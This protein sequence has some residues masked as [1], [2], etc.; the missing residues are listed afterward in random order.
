MSYPR[1]LWEV[2]TDFGSTRAYDPS[3]HTY[4]YTTLLRHLT[5]QSLSSVYLRR[6]LDFCEAVA[7][8]SDLHRRT[9]G[10]SVLPGIQIDESESYRLVG[11]LQ[12]T[13]KEKGRPTYFVTLTC[14][15]R[16]FPG[17]REV[18]SHIESRGSSH[19]LATAHT[20]RVWNRSLELFFSWLQQDPGQP[21]GSIKHYW[22][23]TEFS[24]AASN[25][26]HV[27][28]LIWNEDFNHVGR[29]RD[30]EGF[31]TGERAALSRV[32]GST[33][34]H[35][36]H[37]VACERERERLSALAKRLLT[38]NCTQTCRSKGCP[39]HFPARAT[40]K[41][42]LQ[43]VNDEVPS[44]IAEVLKELG[45]AAPG[46]KGDRLGYDYR[47]V[48][49]HPRRFRG[50]EYV[51][52][53]VPELFIAAESHLNVQVVSSDMQAAYLCS[54]T[55]KLQ[56][57]TLGHLRKTGPATEFVGSSF[58]VCEHPLTA[59]LISHTEVVNAIL[60]NPLVSSDLSYRHLSAGPREERFVQLLGGKR[61]KPTSFTLTPR[62][63][64]G[65]LA[66]RPAS[67]ALRALN[68]IYQS[69]YTCDSIQ[70]YEVRPP[71]LGFMGLKEYYQYTIQAPTITSG[72][73]NQ[74]ITNHLVCGLFD[75]R[76][77][78]VRVAEAMFTDHT[79]RSEMLV[80][81]M[82]QNLDIPQDTAWVRALTCRSPHR[83]EDVPRWVDNPA[84]K[85]VVVLRQYIPFLDY[86]WSYQQKLL[87]RPF[88]DEQV[89]QREPDPI[90]SQLDK[91]RIFLAQMRF[92]PKPQ[93][94]TWDKLH[95]M[96]QKGYAVLSG[97]LLSDVQLRERNRQRYEE[98]VKRLKTRQA[99]HLLSIQLPG[100][101]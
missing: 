1:Y 62:T 16:N 51:S 47:A 36:F 56:H 26:G 23:R 8:D 18:T 14:N 44:S 4:A 81:L 68:R 24:D 66:R 78:E 33:H 7:T 57:R 41:M 70:I 83:S 34:S 76:G 48:R 20:T 64:D 90:L 86:R 88:T 29:T 72:L 96:L 2:L 13:L 95:Q 12:A 39:Q 82:L 15:P 25:L 54:Y 55:A 89:V 50:D 91:A 79:A 85:V 11:E 61:V 99:S 42:W 22:R 94:Y 40:G 69:K 58:E 74:Q 84:P 37:V 71:E 45:Y 87:R 63:E 60:Q 77:H 21:L 100:L 67:G 31:T 3:W 30:R 80:L 6:G 9:F 46:I 53:Y 49:Y 43:V 97:Q 75:L 73:T 17:V 27:H 59:S 10:D 32:T 65:N 92:M 35:E 98:E 5:G 93:R 19:D 52:A 28:A 38:H 101:V